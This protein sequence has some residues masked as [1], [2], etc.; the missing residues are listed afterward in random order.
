M[1]DFWGR[2]AA[3]LRGLCF[4]SPCWEGNLSG[5]I[6]VSCN[7]ISGFLFTFFFVT[8]PS[9]T[10]ASSSEL[11][12]VPF[13]FSCFILSRLRGPFV[14][15][16]CALTAAVVLERGLFAEVNPWLP[17]SVDKRSRIGCGCAIELVST[18]TVSSI[19][20]ANIFFLLI[21]SCSYTN[22]KYKKIKNKNRYE[23]TWKTPSE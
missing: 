20:G 3:C 14:E 8:P 13:N 10:L 2:A 21:F 23:S 19:L 1:F 4:S 17:V 7:S 9:D 15:G 11:L 12:D 18:R 5:R 22:I 6:L 16:L